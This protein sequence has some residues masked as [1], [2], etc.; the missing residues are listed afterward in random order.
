MEAAMTATL[1]PPLAQ[2]GYE[3][4]NHLYSFK[5][6][7]FYPGNATQGIDLED[8]RNSLSN[9][10]CAEGMSPTF[11]YLAVLLNG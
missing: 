8:P 11:S 3:R 9:A 10:F 7:G 2:S 4:L 1:A 6:N 5:F